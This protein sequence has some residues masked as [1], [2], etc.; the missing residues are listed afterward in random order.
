MEHLVENS[1]VHSTH[2]GW[3]RRHSVVPGTK[4]AP[5]LQAEHYVNAGPMQNLQ[6]S[7]QGLQLAIVLISPPG[8]LLI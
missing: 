2:E 1:P 8:L 3:Q 4:K 5:C 6:N 7:L